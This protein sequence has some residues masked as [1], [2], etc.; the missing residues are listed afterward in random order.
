MNI[1]DFLEPDF[2]DKFTYYKYYDE[3]EYLIYT[4]HGIKCVIGNKEHRIEIAECVGHY[5]SGVTYTISKVGW[6]GIR[7]RKEWV[8]QD[9]VRRYQSIF[10]DKILELKSKHEEVKTNLLF[11]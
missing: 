11:N 7:Y 8:P 4:R 9:I 1:L 5:E 2:F 3:I 10:M 6:F